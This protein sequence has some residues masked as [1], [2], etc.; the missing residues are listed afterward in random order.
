LRITDSVNP[1]FTIPEDSKYFPTN[2]NSKDRNTGTRN[3]RYEVLKSAGTL[4]KLER[5]LPDGSF[6]TIFDT[7]GSPFAFSLYY[8]YIQTSLNNDYLYGF[9]ERRKAFRYS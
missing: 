3:Y 8:N 6:E 5:E 2:A 7:T 1:T 9:G 4:F